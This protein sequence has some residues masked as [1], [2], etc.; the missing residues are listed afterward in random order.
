MLDNTKEALKKDVESLKEEFVDAI[1]EKPA[2]I[3]AQDWMGEHN[4]FS[5]IIILAVVFVFIYAFVVPL[6]SVYAEIAAWLLGAIFVIISVGINSI[7]TI[8]EVITKI[9][10]G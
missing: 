3:K 5:R 1:E 9:R 7:K 8:G 10:K 6:D 2:Y 4:V